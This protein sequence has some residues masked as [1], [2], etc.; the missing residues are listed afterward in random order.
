M[1]D[2]RARDSSPLVFASSYQITIP[3]RDWLNVHLEICVWDWVE[4]KIGF[5]RLVS[6]SKETKNER[7]DFD[8]LFRVSSI[9]PS[10]LTSIEKLRS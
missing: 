5:A 2:A 1:T 7:T 10:S 3:D 4:L 9:S 6:S 8:V